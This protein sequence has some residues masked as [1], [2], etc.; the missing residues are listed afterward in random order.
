M[1]IISFETK[2]C[3]GQRNDTTT[4]INGIQDCLFEVTDY[5]EA[6]ELLTSLLDAIHK[7]VVVQWS[8]TLSQQT[9]VRWIPA[10]I[11]PSLTLFL[12]EL[13]V[14]WVE[15]RWALWLLLYFFL[16]LR[17]KTT[18]HGVHQS[19][20]ILALEALTWWQDAAACEKADMMRARVFSCKDPNPS[21]YSVDLI[22]LCLWVQLVYNET[23]R[24]IVDSDT[25]KEVEH[26]HLFLRLSLLIG[27]SG[28]LHG[29]Q[30]LVQRFIVRI[31]ILDDTKAEPLYEFLHF[32][33][34]LQAPGLVGECAPVVIRKWSYIVILVDAHD[35]C[36]LVIGNV[37]I[38]EG[39]GIW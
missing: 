21:F 31:D 16:D 22:E 10:R 18:L 39:E 37:E 5:L 17:M 3:W 4:R 23:V 27:D 6:F 26:R 11:E 20:C 34:L 13:L 14:D 30:H 25:W 35:D 1:I 9:R 12:W 15:I 33:D 28:L 8:F 36:Q 7:Y 24:A 19:V 38:S 32:V 29:L 2:Q